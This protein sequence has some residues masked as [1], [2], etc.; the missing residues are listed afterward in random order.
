MS[1]APISA[2][3]E[4]ELDRLGVSR[5]SRARLS[6]YAEL[7]IQWQQ[8]INLIGPA[9]TSVIWDRH[10]LDSLQLLPLLREAGS[11]ADLGSGAGLPGL[12]LGIATDR[13]VHLYESNQKKSAFLREASRISQCLSEI[14]CVRLEHLEQNLPCP[15]PRYVTARALAPLS[16]LLDWAS[17]LLLRGATGLFH[18]GQDLENE[19][20]IATKC[21]KM[22]II[23]HP[24]AIDSR[25]AIVEITE[26]AHAR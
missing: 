13:Q 10:I 25:G 19:L 7:L 8:K 26:L 3:S 23:R 22:N 16:Q 15:L 6:A 9:T 14:H 18:K 12:V 4:R 20:T 17:P 1:L 21:W 11:I 2:I 5:E 24:S